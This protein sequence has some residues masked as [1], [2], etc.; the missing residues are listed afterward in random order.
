MN[1]YLF[2]ISELLQKKLRGDLTIEEE[3][4][5]IKWM[6]GDE[7]K[8][9]LVE[10]LTNESFI[11]EGLEKLERYDL[12]KN[13]A[14]LHQILLER[15]AKDST[16]ANPPISIS[17]RNRVWRTIAIAASI[18]GF[19]VMTRFLFLQG[20]TGTDSMNPPVLV[21]NDVL[22]PDKSRAQLK[23]ADGSIVLL[24]SAGAGTLA[25]EAG[26]VIVKTA[27]GRIS[28]QS[29]SEV[30]KRELIYNTL[31]N[32]KG[33][34]VV[35]MMLADGSRVWLNAGSSISFPVNF[36]GAERRVKITGEAY[37]EVAKDPMKPF[38][39]SSSGMDV[40]V[41]GT[42]FNIN[43]YED[44]DELKT[45][46]LEGSVR[47]EKGGESTVLIP[48]EQAKLTKDGTIRLDKQA[49][50][51]EVMAWKNGSFYFDGADIQ[52]IVRQVGRWYDV[53]VEFEGKI[54]EGHYRGRPSRNIS[55][56]QMLKV[57]EYSGVKFKVEG[58]KLIIME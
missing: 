50:I 40:R 25:K 2:H 39:V 43:S 8:K 28:Y 32:P 12:E 33:S 11:R 17:R 27:D 20:D 52:T 22:A 47:I 56:S 35:D 38:I 13:R 10:N 9:A 23:L 34:K 57:I 16:S 21:S 46:L 48:G 3:Q 5:L 49:N 19:V 45:T 51:E 7:D 14:Y 31:N 26:T 18:I 1:E 36:I 37:F 24:D 4:E 53:E 42:H 30:S 6:K 54:P 29:S 44:E 41:L 58:K 15:I 55:L